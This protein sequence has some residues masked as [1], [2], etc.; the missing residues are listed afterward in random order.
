MRQKKD[1][2]I[3]LDFGLNEYVTYKYVE[4]KKRKINQ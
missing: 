3:N 2:A 4:E 1:G